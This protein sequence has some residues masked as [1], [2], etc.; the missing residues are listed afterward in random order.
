[1]AWYRLRVLIAGVAVGISVLGCGGVIKRMAIHTMSD[2]MAAGQRVYEREPDLE[3]AAQ[4]LAA[5][6]KLIEVMLESAPQHPVLLLQA[7]QG[8]A[9]YAYAVAEGQLAEAQH[10]ASG[11]VVTHTRRT[12]D[13]YRRGLQYG[14]R[15][16]S[17]HH[18]DW[19]QA[20]S[21]ETDGLRDR[22]QQL[23]PKAVPALFWTAF[24][25]GGVLNMNR[26]ALDTLTALPRFEALLMRLVELDETYF[27][28]APHLLLAVHY[29][30]R[31][32]MLG[33]KPAQAK[34]HFE[35]ATELSQGEL[36]LIPLLEAQ[37]YAVQIQDRAHFVASLQRVLQASEKRL[38][39]QAF[40]NALAKQRAALLLERVN[41][42]FV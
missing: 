41:D 26:D 3:L 7:T 27:Y 15:L 36:L 19:R 1:M 2:M 31:A 33:G 11:D 25:W 5:N 38:P 40:L 24:C 21:L 32:P 8:F 29:A 20:A 9:T 4:A 10:R 18:V 22:L 39:E 23:T 17:R 12:R 28:G 35:R 30:S 6:L 37:Y 13:L 42:L 34:L 14:L 16:L